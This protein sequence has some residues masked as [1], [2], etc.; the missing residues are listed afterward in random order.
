MKVEP[1]ACGLVQVSAKWEAVSARH[2]H[3]SRVMRK[4]VYAF[5][6]TISE[7]QNTLSGTSTA[8]LRC[9]LCFKP[10]SRY[11][12][13]YP[14]SF[15]KIMIMCVFR[16]E[17]GP[18]RVQILPLSRFFFSLCSFWTELRSNPS[19]ASEWISKM[20]LA[21]MLRKQNKKTL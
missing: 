2:S 11:F 12:F 21:V 10:F 5:I 18:I 20:K 3:W 14:N 16:G 17:C 9:W 13:T 15:H 4:I 6:E 1:F 19:S 7:N 8:T